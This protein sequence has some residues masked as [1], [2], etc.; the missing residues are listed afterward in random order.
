MFQSVF[1]NIFIAMILMY[2]R[3]SRKETDLRER[4]LA[5][6]D[7]EVIEKQIKIDIKKA[8]ERKANDIYS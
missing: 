1:F 4:R 3:E 7:D 6:N 2:L 5:K 8:E